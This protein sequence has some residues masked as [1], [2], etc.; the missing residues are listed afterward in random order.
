MRV[1]YLL[2]IL[3]CNIHPGG[4]SN[5]QSAEFLYN[6]GAY[7]QE[8]N[9]RIINSRSM[10]QPEATPRTELI[11][12]EQFLLLGNLIQSQNPN[13]DPVGRRTLPIFLW[14]RLAASARKALYSVSCFLSG[15][16]IP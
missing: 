1:A 5:S 3:A 9:K 12:K 8:L 7:P 11:E 14:S 4:A 13:T 2:G 10:R 15:N 16:E 6:F